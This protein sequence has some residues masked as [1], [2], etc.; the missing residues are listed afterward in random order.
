LCEGVRLDP[1][2]VGEVISDG[3]GDLFSVT[4][5]APFHLEESQQDGEAEAA[6]VRPVGQQ[7]QLFDT[8][9]PMLGEFA[10][11]PVSFHDP[12]PDPDRFPV[13]GTSGWYGG[14]AE[15]A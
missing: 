2:L 8:Q 5:E 4:G 11:V 3:R 6:S 13:C 14:N 15:W 1:E 12:L 9:G 10:L 7:F